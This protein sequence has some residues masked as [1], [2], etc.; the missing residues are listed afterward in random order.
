MIKRIGVL[1]F[2]LWAILTG[3]WYL[4]GSITAILPFLFHLKQADP[5]SIRH[6]GIIMMLLL[7]LVALFVIIGVNLITRKR[8]ALYLLTSVFVV[9]FF[10][11]LF[12]VLFVSTEPFFYYMTISK[13]TYLVWFLAVPLIGLIYVTRKRVKEFFG[14]GKV[15]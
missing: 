8:F 1:I 11:S 10:Y 12:V 9:Q 14:V 13:I 4:F 2:G 3:C 5:I 15:I 7:G 6:N